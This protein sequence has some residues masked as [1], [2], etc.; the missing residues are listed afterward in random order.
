MRSSRKRRVNNALDLGPLLEMSSRTAKGYSLDG[1]PWQRLFTNLLHLT[2]CLIS[3]RGVPWERLMQTTENDSSKPN[4]SVAKFDAKVM[5]RQIDTLAFARVRGRRQ[6]PTRIA[7][8]I[9]C[10]DARHHALQDASR[11]AVEAALER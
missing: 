4:I 5:F 9:V 3:F 7:K 6:R 1:K 8:K 2:K 10:G 11:L